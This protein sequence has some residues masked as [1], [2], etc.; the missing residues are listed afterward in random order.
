VNPFASAQGFVNRPAATIG[1]G[2]STLRSGPLTKP[3]ANY[4][5][6]PAISPYM[7]LFRG[8]DDRGMVNNYYTLVKPELD[9][10]SYNQQTQRQ[11]QSI[12]AAASQQSQQINRLNQQT[13]PQLDQ[14]KNLQQYYPSYRT[15]GR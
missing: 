8:D 9:Q 12:Q 1:A 5:P 2:G 4:T 14:F 7:N 6:P 3:H 10:R 13:S 15:P 11:I